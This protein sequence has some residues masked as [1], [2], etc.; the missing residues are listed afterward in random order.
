[1]NRLRHTPIIYKKGNMIV[2]VNGVERLKLVNGKWLFE[3]V[4][5]KALTHEQIIIFAK[6]VES[7]GRTI[8]A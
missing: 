2:I 6:V 8:K 3:K 5:H 1:M 7:I 4:K